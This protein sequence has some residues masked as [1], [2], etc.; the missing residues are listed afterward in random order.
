MMQKRDPNGRIIRKMKSAFEKQPIVEK[1]Q[2]CGLH[3]DSLCS[4]YLYPAAKWGWCD[5][6]MASHLAGAEKGRFRRKA[7]K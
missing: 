7:K 2:P 1:C 4:V 5:C 6:P 3:R